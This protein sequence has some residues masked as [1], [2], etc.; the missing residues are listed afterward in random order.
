[1]A[2]YLGNSIQNGY[3]KQVNGDFNFD[4]LYNKSKFLRQINNPAPRRKP[5]T[6]ADKKGGDDKKDQNDKKAQTGSSAGE[7]SPVLKVLIRPLLMI[8]RVAVNYSESGSTYLPGYI[9]STGFMGQNWRAMKPGLGFAFGWQPSKQWL[10]RIGREGWLT[11]DSTFNIQYQQQFTQ[12]LDLQATLEPFGGLRID[13]NLNRSFSKNHTELFKDTT[14]HSGFAHLNPY[15]AGGFQETYFSLK[16]MF[17]RINLQNGISETFLNF[18]NYRK[19]I[20]ERLGEKNPY[21][22]GTPDPKDPQYKLGY[23]RYAQDVLIPAF[24]AAYTGEDPKKIGLLNSD[25]GTI[26]SNPV[27]NIAPVPNWKI[28]YNGLSSLPFF[29]KFV[30]NLTISNGYSSILSM[31]SYSSSLLYTDPLGY[32]YPGFIDSTSGN[33]IPYFL[34]PNITIAEQ[35]NPL[36]GIDATFTN[37]LSVS[38]ALSKSR[39]LSMSLVDFQ[40]TEMRSTEI[41]FGAGFRI[42]N[43]PLPFN[44]GKAKKLHNDLNFRLDLGYRDDKTV[45]NLLDADLAIPTSGQ[46]TITIAPSIDYVVNDRLNLHFFYNRRAT[47]PVISTS[48]PISNTEAGV[49]L[50]F[51]LQ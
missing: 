18:E 1:L 13:L 23:N 4:Q 36:L 48:Y 19:I 10:D 28:R 11:R 50:R 37:N 31:N 24:L 41:D 47:I 27:S 21:T 34:I 29:N 42:R 32:G 46:K 6:D 51:I 45:N 49:T 12:Q 25:N 8:K 35:L 17:S 33:Y 20:S 2:A 22:D 3:R 44:I 40:L 30:T 16:T 14:S 7:V 9:D 5:A 38:F 39:M 43:F 26:R 15:D